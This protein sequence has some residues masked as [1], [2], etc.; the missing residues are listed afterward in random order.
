[1][2]EYMAIPVAYYLGDGWN[3]CALPSVDGPAADPDGP[4]RVVRSIAPTDSAFWF[5][6]TRPFHSDSAGRVPE[7]FTHAGLIDRRTEFAGVTLYAGRA[8]RLTTPFAPRA[9]EPPDPQPGS[10][11]PAGQ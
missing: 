10:G 5:V 3:V 11:A 8:R 2:S 4:L 9:C 1:M 7:A 6:Y